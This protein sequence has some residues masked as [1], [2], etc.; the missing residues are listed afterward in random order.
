M[1]SLVLAYLIAAAALVSGVAMAWTSLTAGNR[2]GLLL[3]A[4]WCLIGVMILIG[5][6]FFWSETLPR[7]ERRPWRISVPRF[8]AR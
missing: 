8:R 7:V 3:S 5:R 6:L 2:E 4:V 1:L